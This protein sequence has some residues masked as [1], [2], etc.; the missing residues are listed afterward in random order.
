MAEMKI[1]WLG[2][3]CFRLEMGGAALVLDP[4]TGVRGYPELHTTANA[5]C[6]SHLHGDHGY[7]EA[8]ELT[9]FDGPV[10]FTV[11]KV[12]CFHD[13]CQGQKRGK[14]TIHII[15]Y[16]GLR[17]AHFGDLGHPLSAGQL[18]AVGRL[19]AA[20]VPVGGFYT[21]DA[22]GAKALCDALQPRVIIPMHYKDGP[23]GHDAV[24]G[25]EP[26]LSLWPEGLCVHSAGDSL[27]LSDDTP[28]QVLRLTY[29][30][31]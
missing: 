23:M 2:L 9:P 12:A 5:V 18:A 4:Y 15:E 1:Q 25:V 22:A 11:Q 30:G 13:D 28:R 7:I 26:F 19:D 14:N 24:D 16:Q 6:C 29:G 27:T 17:V 10:P 21:I 20:L 8:V 3:S 31:R